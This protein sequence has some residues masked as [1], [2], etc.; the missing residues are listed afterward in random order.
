MSELDEAAARAADD[1]GAAHSESNGVIASLIETTRR[2]WRLP[3][4]RDLRAEDSRPRER[5]IT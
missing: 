5:A 3:P 2:Q 4:V 1:G